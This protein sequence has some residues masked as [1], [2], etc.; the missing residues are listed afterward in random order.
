ML[1]RLIYASTA[2]VPVDP[3]MIAAILES[4]R[5][6]NL[7]HGI[8][9]ILCEGN[10]KF[11]QYIEGAPERIDELYARLEDDDRHTGLVLLERGTI[12]T[13]AYDDWSMGFVSVRNSDIQRLVLK[14]TEMSHFEPE[15][16][17]AEQALRLVNAF[18][19]Q[20]YPQVSLS[21]GGDVQG[22]KIQ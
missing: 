13:R 9:G 4:A 7:E 15:A 20:L 5:T 11:L 17:T 19:T 22:R 16:L 2:A 1:T 8:T 3:S 21:A 6:F 10:G 14:T 18:K 12:S